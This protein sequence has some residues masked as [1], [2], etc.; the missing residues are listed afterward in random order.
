M[1]KKK[2]KKK[3][4]TM[5]VFLVVNENEESVFPWVGNYPEFFAF[6]EY[7]SRTMLNRYNILSSHAFLS[8][9]ILTFIFCFLVF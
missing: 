2:K 3:K 4:E 6:Y 1:Q 8:W 9:I 7:F 5:V